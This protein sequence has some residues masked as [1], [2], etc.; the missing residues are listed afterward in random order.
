M[1]VSERRQCPA[2]IGPKALDIPSSVRLLLQVYSMQIT[3]ERWQC[4]AY[5]GPFERLWAYMH[6]VGSRFR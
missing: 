3:S 2:Y 6:L 5:T 1:P 4:G